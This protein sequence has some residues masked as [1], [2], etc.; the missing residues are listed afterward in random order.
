MAE[1]FESY[2]PYLTQI[3]AGLHS[4]AISDGLKLLSEV[5]RFVPNEY[6]KT[7]KGT[8]FYLLGI[9]AFLSHDFQTATFFF[10]AAVSE[11]LRNNPAKTDT[12]A[13]L[14]AQLD[15]NNLIQAA[16]PIVQIAVAEIN[17]AIDNYNGRGGSRN[18]TFADLRDH[19][20]RRVLNANQPHLRTLTTTFIS[21]FFEWDYRS[22]MI[23]L[24]K[25]GSREPFFMHLFKGCLLFESLLKENPKKRPT[26]PTLGPI[27][28]SDL[29]VE[30]SIPASLTYSSVPFD[31]IV[32]SLASGQPI[33]A[34]IQCTVRTRNTLG[35]NLFWVAASLD[36]AK[37]N[38]LLEN[39]AASCLHAIS[40]LY[41]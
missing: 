18:L 39:I 29:Y 4:Q 36:A 10:D 32:Q 23:D 12:P 28:K 24:S 20:L 40:C 30:L 3:N 5:R 33:D 15:D 14:F 25:V 2:F 38:L 1:L 35:H 37:Y 8:P 41:R 26:K 7:H 13:L 11:D 22:G 16:L 9:A 27:L 34:T 21:F 17:I 6:E 31:T 19:F